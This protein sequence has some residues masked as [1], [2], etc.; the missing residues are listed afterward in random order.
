MALDSQSLRIGFVRLALSALAFG[1]GYILLHPELLGLCDIIRGYYRNCLWRGD[2]VNAIGHTLMYTS[3]FVAPVVLLAGF[4][5]NN[6]SRQWERFSFWWLSL[7]FLL[8]MFTPEE[9]VAAGYFTYPYRLYVAIL[10]GTLYILI[11]LI[12]IG[13]KSYTL[14]KKS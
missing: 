1:V 7:M 10:L 3:C 11:S 4:V 8:V 14:R 12:L 5:S 6:I 13:W 2:F 9:G